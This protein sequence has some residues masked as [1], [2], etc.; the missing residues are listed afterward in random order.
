MQFPG[1]DENDFRNRDVLAGASGRQVTELQVATNGATEGQ[2]VG[3]SIWTS[4]TIQ[5]GVWNNIG[6]MLGSGGD[7]S[8]IAYGLITLDS[9]REQK[10]RMFAGSNDEHK[11]WLNGQL[12]NEHNGVG[13]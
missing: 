13:R 9:P 12:V 6:R 7:G 10:T 8:N 1:L 11:V 4:G 2:S 3:D 5:S